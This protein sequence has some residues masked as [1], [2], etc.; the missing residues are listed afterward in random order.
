MESQAFQL[1]ALTSALLCVLLMV[2]AGW[3]GATRAIRKQFV[4]PEDKAVNKGAL[5]EREHPDATRAIRAHMNAMENCVP[6]F[7]LG[8]LYVATGATKTGAQG[9]FFTFLGARVVHAIAYLTGKQPLRT[10]AFAVGVAAMFGM[11]F[12]VI[13]AVI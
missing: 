6:F 13:R 11:A 1:Y 12:H 10:I 8:M 7:V 9:Y 2:L 5:V 4:I 3:T